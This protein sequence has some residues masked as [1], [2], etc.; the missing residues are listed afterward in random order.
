[1]YDLEPQGRWF[2]PYGT[3]VRSVVTNTISIK[4]KRDSKE[5]VEVIQL[6]ATQIPTDIIYI[7]YIY[8]YIYIY[9]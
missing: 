8:I 3:Q 1:M 4:Y 5:R 6:K 9:I 7:L 2:K